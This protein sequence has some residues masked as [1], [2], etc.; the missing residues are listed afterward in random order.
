[1]PSANHTLPTTPTVT[2][3]THLRD[4]LTNLYFLQIQAYNYNGSNTAS[5]MTAEVRRLVDN[6][7]LFSSSATQLTSSVPN[8]I[9]EYVENGRNPDIYTREFVELVQ[10]FNQTLKGKQE[11]FR[12]FSEILAEEIRGGVPALSEDVGRVMENGGGV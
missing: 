10:R 11:G 6:L 4:L 9:L 2:T 1:M 12:E 3:E 5:A 8:E 7:Q